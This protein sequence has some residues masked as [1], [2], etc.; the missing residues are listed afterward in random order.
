MIIANLKCASLDC[1]VNRF[2]FAI[3][4]LLKLPFNPT[5]STPSIT[6]RKTKKRPF[7]ANLPVSDISGIAP[8]MEIALS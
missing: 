1:D 6:Y 3:L 7:P 5:H 4:I 8:A 2:I